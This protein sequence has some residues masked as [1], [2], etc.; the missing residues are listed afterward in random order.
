MGPFFGMQL[1][2]EALATTRGHERYGGKDDSNDVLWKMSG[3]S[4]AQCF[5]SA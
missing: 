1:E 4:K 2:R 3:R 5:E